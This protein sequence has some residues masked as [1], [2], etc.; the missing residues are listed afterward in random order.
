MSDTISQIFSWKRF[1]W[2]LINESILDCHKSRWSHKGAMMAWTTA[3]LSC[4]LL[5]FHIGDKYLQCSLHKR[6]PRDEALIT[7]TDCKRQPW[8]SVN[9]YL[10]AQLYR[11]AFYAKFV[12]TYALR[13]NRLQCSINVELCLLN[14]LLFRVTHACSISMNTYFLVF[15]IFFRDAKCIHVGRVLWLR[16]HCVSNGCWIGATI[17]ELFSTH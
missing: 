8:A 16:Q 4:L 10:R 15:K 9:F 3:Q 2:I 7:E 13:L 6:K 12:C 5:S 17:D 1:S 14:Y 11:F